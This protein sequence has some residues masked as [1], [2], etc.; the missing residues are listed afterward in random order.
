MGHL[1]FA[2]PKTGRKLATFV[3]TDD[4]TLLTLRRKPL[5][6]RLMPISTTCGQ[7]LPG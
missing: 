7:P 4:N 5:S 3:G 2:C 6:L 1:A